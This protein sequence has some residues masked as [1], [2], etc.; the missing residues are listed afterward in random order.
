MKQS[1]KEYE[2]AF[3]VEPTKLTR[4]L[5]RIH[6]RLGDQEPAQD[7]FE[8]FLTGGRREEATSLDQVLALENSRKRKIKRLII[9]CSAAAIEPFGTKREIEV[10][11]GGPKTGGKRTAVAIRVRSDDAG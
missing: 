6:E 3:L 7:K 2:K 4:L 1:H 10:D 9:L 8:V 11:F 5:E